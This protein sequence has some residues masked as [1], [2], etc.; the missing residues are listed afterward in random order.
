MPS[1]VAGSA[2][3]A[4]ALVGSLT[5][6]LQL[7]VI[8]AQLGGM[9]SKIHKPSRALLGALA[10]RLLVAPA[11]TL[12]LAWLAMK[13]GFVLPETA[14]L[15]LYLIAAMPVA[16]SAAMFTERYGGDIPLGAQG[17]FYSTFFSI[18]TV[19]VIFYVVSKLG[20]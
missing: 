4:L 16:I 2:V 14:R 5:S 11:V 8:G 3:Q 6:P 9:V 7:L 13:G 18:L 17:I 12:A 10:M 19:P 1:L 15:C 20:L